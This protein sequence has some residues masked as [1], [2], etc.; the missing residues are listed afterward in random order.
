MI[1]LYL[2]RVLPCHDEQ[3]QLADLEFASVLSYAMSRLQVVKQARPRC[4]VW[5]IALVLHTLVHHPVRI[6]FQRFV[7]AADEQ[8]TRPETMTGST[9]HAISAMTAKYHCGRHKHLRPR[10]QLSKLSR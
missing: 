1:Y 9:P 8:N 10:M 3:S 6:F 2:A 5:S 7:T 4:D